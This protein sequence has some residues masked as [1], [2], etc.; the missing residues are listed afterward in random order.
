MNDVITNL[1]AISDQEDF[2]HQFS[3]KPIELD[4]IEEIDGK[5][6][7]V[8]GN[9]Q[10]TIVSYKPDG[11]SRHCDVCGKPMS[12]GYYDGDCLS[13]NLNLEYYCSRECMA[14][15]MPLTKWDNLYEDDGDSYWTEWED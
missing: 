11:P 13:G 14:T 9:T 5:K 15:V 6:Y 4:I 2:I 12:E 8:I 3:T 1:R 7:K 10:T